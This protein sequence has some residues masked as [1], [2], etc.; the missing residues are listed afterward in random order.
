MT[1]TASKTG[2]YLVY[3]NFLMITLDTVQ[4]T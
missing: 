4:I 2:C 3:F 1:L